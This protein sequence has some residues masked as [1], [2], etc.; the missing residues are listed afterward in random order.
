[1]KITYAQTIQKMT[2]FQC[3][4]NTDAQDNNK[5][6]SWRIFKKNLFSL[7]FLQSHDLK[8]NFSHSSHLDLKSITAVKTGGKWRLEK[9][10]PLFNLL[11]IIKHFETLAKVKLGTV[12]N[13]DFLYKQT[14]ILNLM[15]QIDV[16][17][18]YYSKNIFSL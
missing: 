5:H 2:T 11:I 9:I 12:V 13:T 15:R 3:H 10:I 8:Y 14:I 17:Y 1:M 6:N 4:T 7:C 16:V 18:R